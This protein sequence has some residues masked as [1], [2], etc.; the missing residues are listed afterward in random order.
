[1]DFLS[2]VG[3][4]SQRVFSLSSADQLPAF[5]GLAAGL[6]AALDFCP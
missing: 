2:K 4:P 3:P 1:M 5:A 6:G